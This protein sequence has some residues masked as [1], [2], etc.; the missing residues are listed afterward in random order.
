M[1]WLSDYRST[2]HD[3]RMTTIDWAAAGG[4]AHATTGQAAATAPA[5]AHPAAEL[6]E[7]VL[8]SAAGLIGNTQLVE[9]RTLAA[10]L[11]GRV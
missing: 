9:L 4:N 1:T 2:I 7:E 3:W 6:R 8:A 10:G 5:A 11:P